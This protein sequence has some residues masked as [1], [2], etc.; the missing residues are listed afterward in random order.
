MQTKSD[1]FFSG[2]SILRLIQGAMV[3]AV[4]T[5][6]IGFN[7]VGAGFGWVTGGTADATARRQFQMGAYS[8]LAIECA[9]A[10][11]QRADATVMRA[12]F[13]KAKDPWDAGRV[14]TDDA[15]KKLITLDG[16]SWPDNELALACGKAVLKTAA[17]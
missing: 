13:E 10:V 12:G 4:I 2:N 1:G 3:G 7:W 17:K 11:K 14:F 6:V 15:A 9:K 5:V 8:I 16:Q